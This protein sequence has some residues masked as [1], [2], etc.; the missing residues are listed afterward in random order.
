MEC[1]IVG[2]GHLSAFSWKYGQWG[3]IRGSNT[4]CIKLNRTR[5]ELGTEEGRRTSGG[6]D[7]SEAF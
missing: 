7:T 6:S 1:W 5:R 2:S 4:G 3:N